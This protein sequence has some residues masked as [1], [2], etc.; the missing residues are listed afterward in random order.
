MDMVAFIIGPDGSMR[1]TC[2]SCGTEADMDSLTLWINRKT[3]QAIALCAACRQAQ[4]AASSE[5]HSRG[6][7]GHFNGKRL[8]ILP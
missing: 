7:Q 5:S 2:T 4:K 3:Q 1:A 6:F 8:I